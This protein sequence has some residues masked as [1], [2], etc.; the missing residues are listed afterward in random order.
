MRLRHVD[1]C[2]SSRRCSLGGAL[3]CAQLES[4]NPNAPAPAITIGGPQRR[5]RRP[6]HHPDRHDQPRDR[7]QLHL[8]QR[9]PGH[10]DRRR[11]R[12]RHRRRARRDQRDRDRRR[13][14]RPPPARRSSSRPTPS[15]VPFYDAWTMSP[16]SDSTAQAFNHWNT[17]GSVPV[18]CARCHSRQGFIDYLGG[19]GSAPLVVDQPAPTGSVVDCQTCHR[20]GRQHAGAGD[21]PFGRDR[22]RPRRRGPLHDLP[23]GTIVR[24][25]RRRRDRGRGARR[26]RHG[27][28]RCSSSQTSTTRRPPPRSTG[29]G[30]R[31]ATSTPGR[32][33]TCGS[34]TST[35]P[36]PASTCHDPHSTQV[37][38][39]TC[40]TCHAGVTDLAGAQQIRME[41]SIGIDYDGDGNVSGG[42]SD[43]VNGLFKKLGTA[44]VDLRRR[45]RHADL[46]RAR[47]LS[48]LVR[49]H[50]RR[51]RLLGRRGDGQQR[52]STA[53]PRAWC[54]PPTTTSWS[55]TTRAPSPTTPSTSSS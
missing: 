50:R 29:A 5:R 8:R 35:A 42:I 34:A 16:H 4:D 52:A 28:R 47:Q 53:G 41:S 33:T 18:E 22:H 43:E 21:L 54:A 46:L 55:T 12:R 17:Q 40:A 39:T 2:F 19:D 6:D 26:R 49:R 48:L 36:T 25:H 45:A 20:P 3:G 27:Q 10:R 9:Q 1:R 13:R 15:Q 32:A 31:A 11:H 51:R 44:I 23:S 7:H 30:R 14:R 38:F 24:A 37:N